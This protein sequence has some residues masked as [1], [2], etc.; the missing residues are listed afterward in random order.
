MD[1]SLRNFVLVGLVVATL[2]AVG[3]SQFA[4]DDPDGLEYVADR[5]GFLETAQDHDLAETALADYGDGLTGN[6]ALDTAIA[7]VVGVA[8]TA[9]LGWGLFW[10][11]RRRGAP[12][13]T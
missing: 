10:L 11:V 4:S 5:E 3:L 8:V 12:T 6:S 13:A 2:I 7:G 9:L 1:R